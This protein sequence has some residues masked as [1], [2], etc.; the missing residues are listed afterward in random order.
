MS[1]EPI[2]KLYNLGKLIGQGNY[3]TVR[4]ATPI[5]N[6]SKTVAIKSIPRDLIEKE[7]NMLEQELQILLE[8]DHPNIIKFY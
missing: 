8:V 6:P 4:L 7:I 2:R 5:S 1:K 3:G